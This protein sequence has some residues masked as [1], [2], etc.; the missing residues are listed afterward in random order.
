M[1][2]LWVKDK[3]GNLRDIVLGYDD[4]VCGYFRILFHVM[5]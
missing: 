1:T 5:S 2:E 4:N 3:F